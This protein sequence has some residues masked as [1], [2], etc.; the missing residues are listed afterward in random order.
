M[1]SRRKFSPEV[2]AE[3][4]KLVISSGRPVVR[5]AADIGVNEGALGNWV[6]VWKEERLLR[7]EATIDTTTRL[8][9]RRRPTTSSTGCASD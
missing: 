5:V 1:S 3:A 6:R 9:G 7:R 2:K 4:I 8:S